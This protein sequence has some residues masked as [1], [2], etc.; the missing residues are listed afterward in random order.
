MRNLNSFWKMFVHSWWGRSLIGAFIG[1]FSVA[2][3][4]VQEPGIFLVGMLIG[5]VALFFLGRLN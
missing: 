3:L 4:G 1:G 5:A 2:F